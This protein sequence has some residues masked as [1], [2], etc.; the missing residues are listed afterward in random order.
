MSRELQN[1]EFILK[2][3]LGTVNGSPI[4]KVFKGK[5]GM[6][7][8]TVNPMVDKVE[9]IDTRNCVFNVKAIDD[10][11]KELGA[12]EDIPHEEV[13]PLMIEDKKQSS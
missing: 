1:E 11:L 2:G 5:N 9:I 7:T 10:R 12:L 3:D 6:T 13:K 4:T 8:I